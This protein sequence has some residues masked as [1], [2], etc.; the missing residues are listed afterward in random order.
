VTVEQLQKILAN[1]RPKA[2]V[3]VWDSDIED[4]VEAKEVAFDLD[5]DQ[6]VVDIDFD[7]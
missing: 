5:I 7:H 6:D 1:A 4:F 3:R 2:I